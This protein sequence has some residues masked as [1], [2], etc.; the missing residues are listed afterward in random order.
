MRLDSLGNRVAEG[1]SGGVL[2]RVVLRDCR[3]RKR[4]RASDTG[5]LG[6]RILSG[7]DHIPAGWSSRRVA[8]SEIAGDDSRCQLADERFELLFINHVNFQFSSLV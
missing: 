7:T 3:N 6:S 8:V 2:S 1:L 5:D 4:N